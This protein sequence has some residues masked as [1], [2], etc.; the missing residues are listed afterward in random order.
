[1]VIFL[2]SC[3]A[4]TSAFLDPVDQVISL[5]HAPAGVACGILTSGGSVDSFD[6]T[7]IF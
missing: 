6:F 5:L 2:P 4:S 7:K 3:R 1:M